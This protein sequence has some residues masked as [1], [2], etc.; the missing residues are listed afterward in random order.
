MLVCCVCSGGRPAAVT[1]DTVQSFI[2]LPNGSL[3]FKYIVEGANLFFTQ[4]AREEIEKAGIIV[5]KGTHHVM[6]CVCVCVCV[7]CDWVRRFM[8][9]C[10]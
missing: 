2:R 1:V 9:V 4:Q 7:S 3:R 10:G 8:L 5:F 6:S